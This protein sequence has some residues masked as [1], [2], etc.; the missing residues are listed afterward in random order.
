MTVVMVDD[1]L[2][3]LF[4]ETCSIFQVYFYK[5]LF[6]PD[7]NGKISNDEHLT[8]KTVETLLNKILSTNKNENK[9]R[10]AEFAKKNATSLKTKLLEKVNKY[11]VNNVCKRYLNL[12]FTVFLGHDIHLEPR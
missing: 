4:S 8:K 11:F 10:V 12:Y 2:Q 6:G 3:E 5:H 7:E 9:C 1:E